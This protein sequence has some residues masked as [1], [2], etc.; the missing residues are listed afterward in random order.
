VSFT[1]AKF[2][3]VV[4]SKKDSNSDTRNTFLGSLGFFL[5]T[6]CNSKGF[7]ASTGVVTVAFIGILANNSADINTALDLYFRVKS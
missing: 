7:E 1:Q 4:V 6:S 2:V 3:G 5:I